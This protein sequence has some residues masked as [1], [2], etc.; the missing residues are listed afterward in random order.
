MTIDFGSIK[1][2]NTDRGFGF[3]GRTFFDSDE[4]IFFHIKKMKKKH[5]KLAQ[6]LDNN[7]DIESVNFW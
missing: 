3:V 5:P 1:S 7:E 4:K 6:K 2:Y